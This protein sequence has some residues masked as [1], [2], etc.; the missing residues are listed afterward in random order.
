MSDFT[1]ARDALSK[2]AKAAEDIQDVRAKAETLTQIGHGF[3]RLGELWPTGQRKDDD[4]GAGFQP[5][6]GQTDR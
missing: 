4:T 5:H 1:Q 6:S 2:A 3:M